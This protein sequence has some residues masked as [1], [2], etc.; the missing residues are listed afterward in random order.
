MNKLKALF[1]SVF[2]TFNALGTIYTVVQI[3]TSP[4]VLIWIAAFVSLGIG[5]YFFSIIMLRHTP[6]TST[7]L[8]PYLIINLIATILVVILFFLGGSEVA[9]ILAG[10]ATFGWLAYVFWYSDISDRNKDQL[11]VG[12]LLDNL[13]FED[14]DGQAV[15][16]NDISSG[17]KVILFYRGN[18]CPFCVAQVKDLAA[19]YETIKKLGA[20][21]IFISSQHAGHTKKLSRSLNIGAHFLIDTNLKNAKS[22]GIDH[23]HGIPLGMELLGYESDTVMPTALVLDKNNLIIYSNLTDVYRVRP[24]PSEFIN[25]LKTQL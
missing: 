18:W 7:Y 5:A 22:L 4:I 13:S 15:R 14:V 20:E 8:T 23:E 10:M 9:L 12:M 3:F 11:K 16:L 21:I 6:T 24:E 19:E 17:P 25:I 2:I 1:A